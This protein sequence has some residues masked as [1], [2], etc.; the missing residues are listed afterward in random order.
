MLLFATPLHSVPKGEDHC[1]DTKNIVM[2]SSCP[3]LQSRQNPEGFRV[4]GLRVSGV[5][6]LGGC[7]RRF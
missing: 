1:H 7:S 3:V 2:L 5:G 6:W 4:V